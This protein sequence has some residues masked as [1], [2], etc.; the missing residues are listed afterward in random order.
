MDNGLLIDRERYLVSGIHVGT[1]ALSSDMERFVVR[2]RPDG[3]Y[4]MDI[5][6]IDERL[7]KAAKILSKFEPDE[8]VVT[9]SR[10]Y[11]GYSARKFAEMI[12]ARPIIGRFVPGTFTNPNIKYYVEPSIVLISDPRAERRAVEEAGK[13]NIPIV[14]LADT[15]HTLEY[16]DWVIPCNNKGRKSVALIYYLLTRQ[17]LLSSGRIASIE[18]FKYR[19]ED[20]EYREEE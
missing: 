4:V 16:V 19:P 18:E 13:M 10:I 1:K 3:I 14:A 5:S 20:F 8:V 7:R 6:K 2:K 9:A 11:A 12:G 17:Y 15:E